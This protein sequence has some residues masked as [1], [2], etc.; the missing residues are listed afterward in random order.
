MNDIVIGKEGSFDQKFNPEAAMLAPEYLRLKKNC[1]AY[2]LLFPMLSEF[3][4]MPLLMS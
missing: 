4:M 1:I 2:Q 3:L